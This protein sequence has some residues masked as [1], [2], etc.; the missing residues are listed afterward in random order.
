[1]P[2]TLLEGNVDDAD[3]EL[4]PRSDNTGVTKSDF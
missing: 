2:E 1:M 3:L 4:F